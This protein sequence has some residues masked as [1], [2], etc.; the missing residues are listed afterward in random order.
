MINRLLKTIISIMFLL[1]Y[2]CY[3]TAC[4]IFK[5]K[6]PSTLTI[7]T[8][9]SITS[10]QHQKFIRQ[11]D[12]LKKYHPIFPGTKIEP[13]DGRHYVAVTFDDGFEC[14]IENA[15]P[16]L[17]KR[18]IPA[19]FFI[20]TG[21]LGQKPGWITDLNNKNINEPV[22]SPE[23]LQSLQTELIKIGSHSITHRSLTQLQ[24][25][26]TMKELVGSK[27]YLETLLRGKINNFSF[28]YGAYNNTVLELA[29]KAGY[30]SVFCSCPLFP[31]PKKNGFLI[32]R[33]AASPNDTALEFR[34]K[35][36]GSYQWLPLGIAVKR[37]I[38]DVLKIK[39]PFSAPSTEKPWV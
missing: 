37:H 16:E 13:N 18:N 33:T 28:P 32:G 1:G 6:S 31:P 3:S 25:Q 20:P 22:M 23:R 34:L 12:M 35:L 11:M 39:T 2:K 15:L 4:H 7:L 5:K 14:I 21:Y 24:E 10:D 38:F 9:H 27:M 8:Y 29:Q 26:E 36:M 19:M 30:T 17:I